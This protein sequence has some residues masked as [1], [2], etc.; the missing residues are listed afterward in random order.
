M[1]CAREE[2]KK[3]GNNETLTLR[4][5]ARKEKKAYQSHLS[6]K[7]GRFLR[8]HADVPPPEGGGEGKGGKEQEGA[9]LLKTVKKKSLS[10]YRR[11]KSRMGNVAHHRANVVPAN[12]KEKKGRK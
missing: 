1:V 8:P 10:P 2:K 7:K 9:F 4:L 6:R 11:K 3:G 12:R 5:V